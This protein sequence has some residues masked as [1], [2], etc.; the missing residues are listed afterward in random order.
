MSRDQTSSDSRRR[1]ESMSRTSVPSI[2]HHLCAWS[3]LDPRGNEAGKGL[4]LQPFWARAGARMELTPA[5][6]PTALEMPCGASAI[7]SVAFTSG[8]IARTVWRAPIQNSLRSLMSLARIGA[9]AMSM[10]VNGA[11][12]AGHDEGELS[13]KPLSGGTRRRGRWLAFSLLQPGR[14]FEGFCKHLGRTDLITDE[15]FCTVE[16]L[17]KRCRLC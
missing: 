15:R 11:L 9:W 17:W 16:A 10:V 13:P 2:R 6:H 14:Y 4:R 1:L 3:A 12:L 7:A 8:A 5:G